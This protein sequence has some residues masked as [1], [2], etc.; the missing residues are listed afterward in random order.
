MLRD[1]L[2]IPLGGLRT[3]YL[4][5]TLDVGGSPLILRWVGVGRARNPPHW[6]RPLPVVLLNLAL[7]M[8]YP[9]QAERGEGGR[10]DWRHTPDPLRLEF[11]LALIRGHHLL[12]LVGGHVRHWDGGGRV[13]LDPLYPSFY[14]DRVGRPRAFLGP[15]PDF[16]RY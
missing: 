12:H 11:L 1:G 7:L 15:F 14:L 6:L 2:R 10:A 3:R 8:G 9:G 5:N 13:V 16:P 4:G